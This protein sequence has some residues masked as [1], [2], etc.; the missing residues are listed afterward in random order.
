MSEPKKG[1]LQR[2]SDGLS[3]TSRQMTEQVTGVIGKRP[4][5]QAQLDEL[6]EMLIEADLGP[7]AAARIAEAFGAE[8]FGRQVDEAEIKEA[9]AAAVARELAP[10]QG[11]F[12]PLS[13]P[14]P[15][16]VLFVGVNGSGKTTT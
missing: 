4:L 6:E 5:D 14:K 8:R 7:A 10:R 11:D 1:W 3:R 16:V 2:L 13:G 12:D 15:F 9:L